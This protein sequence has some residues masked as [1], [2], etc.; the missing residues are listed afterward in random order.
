MGIFKLILVDQ[1]TLVTLVTRNN[2]FFFFFLVKQ[3]FPFFASEVFKL[4][5]HVPHEYTLN[6][7]C[8]Q[9]RSQ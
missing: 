8:S 5:S 1:L 6:T 4:W 3:F 7:L 9:Q 2:N